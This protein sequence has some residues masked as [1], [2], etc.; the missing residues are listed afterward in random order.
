MTAQQP[1]PGWS[2]DEGIRFEVARNILG[3][4]IGYAAAQIDAEQ[5]GP[6]TGGGQVP[7]WAERRQQWATRR[8]TLAPGDPDVDRILAEEGPLLRQLREDEGTPT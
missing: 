3:Q 7:T 5:A 2:Q 4:L 8:L 1:H 6:P